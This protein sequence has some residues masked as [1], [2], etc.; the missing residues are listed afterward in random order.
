MLSKKDWFWILFALG[1]TWGLDRWTKLEA[2]KLVGTQ[3][4][5]YMLFSLHY[6][7]GAILGLFSQLPSVLRVV[8][9]STGGAFLIFTYFILQ[10]LIPSRAMVLRIGMSLL[11]GGIIGNV[12]DRI[13]WGH[14][15][16]FIS[17][18]YGSQLTPIFNVAD[19]IQW[20]GHIMIM[21]SLVKNAEI[22]WPETNVRKT[23]WVNFRFQ[24]KYFLILMTVGLGMGV[25]AGIFSYTYLRVT[26]LTLTGDNHDL[27]E[28]YLIPFAL[29]LGAVNGIFLGGLYLIGKLLSLRVA[30][31]VYAFEKYVQ[32]LLSGNYRFFKVRSSDEFQELTDLG[33]QLREH[34][35]SKDPQANSK[36]ASSAATDELSSASNKKTSSEDGDVKEGVLPRLVFTPQ[37]PPPPPNPRLNSDDV[38]RTLRASPKLQKIKVTPPPP[39]PPPEP[40]VNGSAISAA[41]AQPPPSPLAA[42]VIPEA[43][44]SVATP[45]VIEEIKPIVTDFPA[46]TAPSTDD[47]KQAN[48]VIQ[49]D[50]KVQ[51]DFEF[52]IAALQPHF[53]GDPLEDVQRTVQHTDPDFEV[54]LAEETVIGIEVSI[55][56]QLAFDFEVPQEQQIQLQE[57]VDSPQINEAATNTEFNEETVVGI[58]QTSTAPTTPEP[59]L[60]AVVEVLEVVSGTEESALHLAFNP[61]VE[62]Q[63]TFTSEYSQ[64]VDLLEITVIREAAGLLP[65]DPHQDPSA[66]DKSK[67]DSQSA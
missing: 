30:G 56:D 17:F 46:T 20:V 35:I 34:F 61:P 65:D 60:P 3:D 16:D 64:E 25:I 42:E 45:S 7:P 52:S 9:L 41:V 50:H 29:S 8:T 66:A 6:N 10:Y 59:E 14:V 21:Y 26:L 53:E 27:A 4:Y 1:A 67:K 11:L 47:Q 22:F 28:R 43:K 18:R 23:Q 49:S 44:V 57:P 15:V 32:D 40:L 58:T 55:E 5:G 2:L 51:D 39:P 37:S 33:N 38:S 63:E 31:P 24:I 13:A 62:T 54:E 36:A 12:A 48:E 19:A